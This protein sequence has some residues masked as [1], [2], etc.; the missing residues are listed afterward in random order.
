M[1]SVNDTLLGVDDDDDLL[2]IIGCCLGAGAVRA[3]MLSSGIPV[4]SY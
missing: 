4:V 1:S 2:D 3:N